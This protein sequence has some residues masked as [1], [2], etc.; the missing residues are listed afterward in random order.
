M[1]KKDIGENITK[2][3][4]LCLATAYVSAFAP[5]MVPDWL[6]NGDFTT[7]SSLQ[8]KLDAIFK[9]AKYFQAL[10]QYESMLAMAQT[11]FGLTGTVHGISVSDIYLRLACAIAC[12]GLNRTDEARRYLIEALNIYL[13]HGF[14]TPFAESAQAFNGLLEQILERDFPSYYETVTRQWIQTV[15]NWIRFHNRFTKDNITSMLSL[16]DYQ[17][18]SLVAR[19]VPYKEIARQFNISVGRLSNIMSEIYAELFVSNRDELAR[20]IL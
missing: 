12:C 16:R 15:P 4:E 3:A 6:K 9:R 8:L 2:A 11:T 18:A 14:I 1:I 19:R 7:L 17:L 5:S 20:F 10:K 13:P